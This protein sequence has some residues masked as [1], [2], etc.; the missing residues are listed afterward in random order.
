MYSGMDGGLSVKTITS[1]DSCMKFYFSFTC[2]TCPAVF[3]MS[4]FFSV[5][6]HYL[7]LAHHILAVT[8]ESTC[9]INE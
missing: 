6:I 3:S 8:F 7:F 9:T 4:Q 2:P 1:D 5:T